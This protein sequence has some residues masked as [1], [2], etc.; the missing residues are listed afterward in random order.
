MRQACPALA[1]VQVIVDLL[2]RELERVFLLEDHHAVVAVE[3]RNVARRH[4]VLALNAPE[5]VLRCQLVEV[6]EGLTV[7]ALKFRVEVEVLA[8]NRPRRAQP[9][10]QH[11]LQR[12][13]VRHLDDLLL[14]DAFY[15]AELLLDPRP[16]RLRRHQVA[17]RSADVKDALERAPVVGL[18]LVDDLV[19][20]HH[21]QVRSHRH[22]VSFP[23]SR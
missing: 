13:N 23:E 7:A 6:V 8:P 20:L 9:V 21:R 18:Q 19:E 11:A 17:E 16:H 4:A 5:R 10:E 3:L 22:R 14:P 1:G 15:L 12:H 2:P